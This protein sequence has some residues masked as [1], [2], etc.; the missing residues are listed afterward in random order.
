MSTTIGVRASA[1]L[2]QYNSSLW[3]KGFSC[4]DQLNNDRLVKD[5]M[6]S[7]TDICRLSGVPRMRQVDRLTF[8]SY[9]LS[10]ILVSP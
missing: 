4:G 5:A 8:T 3:H 2:P 10:D 6:P 7:A 1:T 9:Q